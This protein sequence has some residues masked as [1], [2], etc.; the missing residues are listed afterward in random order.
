[1]AND[2]PIDGPSNHQPKLGNTGADNLGAAARTDTFGPDP[3][4]QRTD[5]GLSR[6]DRSADDFGGTAERQTIGPAKVEAGQLISV[7]DSHAERIG[8]PPIGER[9]SNFSV[10]HNTNVVKAKG[11]EGGVVAPPV[12]KSLVPASAEGAR[13]LPKVHGGSQMA[14]PVEQRARSSVNGDLA[15][16]VESLGGKTFSAINEVARDPKVSAP[17]VE[18]KPGSLNTAGIQPSS[19][20]GERRAAQP[21]KTVNSPAAEAAI[22]GNVKTAVPAGGNAIEFK[23][24]DVK[25]SPPRVVAEG[26]P[27]DHP[28]AR[29]VAPGAKP[30][31]DSTVR[32]KTGPTSPS[33]TADAN[34]RTVAEFK[35]QKLQSTPSPSPGSSVESTQVRGDGLNRAGI[36]TGASS[37]SG[38]KEV[39]S[40]APIKTASIDGALKTVTH[41]PAGSTDVGATR[42]PIGLVEGGKVLPPIDGGKNMPPNDGVKPS[43]VTAAND[44][45]RVPPKV[46]PGDG[47]PLSTEP[48]AKVP[49]T[50]G[51]GGGKVPGQNT[52]AKQPD[53]GK[54][55]GVKSGSKTDGIK[56]EGVKTEGA[57][58]DGVKTEGVKNDGVKADVV[59]TGSIKSDG[60]K[61]DG[62]KPGGVKAGSVKPDGVRTD[63]GKSPL[64]N[65]DVGDKTG[66]ATKV[67]GTTVGDSKVRTPEKQQSSSNNPGDKTQVP[68]S[69]K[70]S[71]IAANDVKIRTPEF[72]SVDGK[73]SGSKS[74]GVKTDSANDGKS[75]KTP[76]PTIG[77]KGDARPPVE[78]LDPRAGKEKA[79]PQIDPG[80]HTEAGR[81]IRGPREADIGTRTPQKGDIRQ[82]ADATGR[83]EK[84]A[85]VDGTRGDKQVAQSSDSEGKGKL[86]EGKNVD[87]SGKKQNQAADK[88]SNSTKG[89][90]G[91]KEGSVT[92]GT[93]DGA[94]SRTSETV[95]KGNEKSPEATGT[96]L[97]E[98]KRSEASG[99]KATDGSKQPGVIGDKLIDGAKNPGKNL[100]GIRGLRADSTAPSAREL[101]FASML[102]QRNGSG[103]NEFVVTKRV[104]VVKQ[105]KFEPTKIE[106]A[107]PASPQQQSKSPDVLFERG[108]PSIAKAQPAPRG[109]ATGG[110]QS[111]T[112]RGERLKIPTDLAN[113]PGENATRT[114][115]KQQ[116]DGTIIKPQ[117]AGT[118]SA[119]GKSGTAGGGTE[120]VESL[121]PKQRRETASQNEPPSDT[122][123]HS[124][125]DVFRKFQLS[126]PKR[127]F[128]PEITDSGSYIA[129]RGPSSERLQAFISSGQHKA[130]RDWSGDA[131]TGRRRAIPVFEDDAEVDELESESENDATVRNQNS[132]E[133]TLAKAAG[134]GAGQHDTVRR[135]YIVQAGDTP[136]SIA[137]VQ[138]NDQSLENLIVEINEPIFQKRYDAVKGAHVKV[139]PEG[140]MILLPNARDIEAWLT[141]HH[142]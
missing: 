105:S 57:K 92:R 136:H 120:R 26:A 96:K 46:P 100:I 114:F 116:P 54:P 135:M 75:S 132:V 39:V 27:V 43:G 131:S 44:G 5:V 38:Q 12:D 65:T 110:D 82:P 127:S 130:L 95:G 94:S 93:T 124:I 36:K 58:T 74:D 4:S 81:T 112:V 8:D 103:V 104:E 86:G 59:K 107:K 109:M 64:T 2:P 87:D 99:V 33:G 62:V 91:T 6:T 17:G 142:I 88:E 56:S 72:K 102:D 14:A 123:P 80:S 66:P 20:E 85:K 10:D 79:T 134:T 15:P 42:G 73:T 90:A 98:G 115:A 111:A 28:P 122:V 16:T 140:A 52:G 128:S 41:G 25:S 129:Q 18:V 19:A 29:E 125:R 76:S 60:V 48:G 77:G 3:K 49:A 50:T 133:L 70:A 71:G 1:M 117:S 45:V 11:P 24:Q 13:D 47:K 119:A 137:V 7:L 126:L 22:D 78:R 84:A 113:V 141:Q 139:L 121:L 69:S 35:S 138:L 37:E 9:P 61:T 108:L 30:A 31:D 55:D 34:S 97:D 21:E 32:N 68:G 51:D 40:P 63:G 89:P 53:G 101:K 118:D 106:T 67:S 23:D 83:G